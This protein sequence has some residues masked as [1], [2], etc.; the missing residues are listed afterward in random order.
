MVCADSLQVSRARSYLG[1]PSGGHTISSTGVPPSTPGLSMPFDYD[2]TFLLLADPAG[3]AEGS[4]NPVRATPAGLHTHTVWPDPL[5][6]ATTHGI[7]LPAGTEM[8][9]FPAFPPHTLYIQ[10]RVTAHDCC[11]VSPFGHPRITVRLPT[12][13]GL[14]QATTSFFG[15]WCQGIHPVPF[16]TSTTENKDARVHCA[17]LK[18]PPAPVPHERHQRHE[19]TRPTTGMST[20]TSPPKPPTPNRELLPQDPTVCRERSTPTHD[21]PFPPP[22]TTSAGKKLY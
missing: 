16:T 4:H 11:G 7:S 15:S 22:P 9:H 21:H 5:S 10:V 13:R 1:S 6:L 20:G 17:V 8:F 3:S 14:S 18:Q 19:A 2:V 12:P